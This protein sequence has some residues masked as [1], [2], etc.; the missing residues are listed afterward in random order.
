MKKF[1]EKWEMMWKEMQNAAI[2]QLR[3]PYPIIVAYKPM[4]K[5]MG[6]PQPLELPLKAKLY[7]H[8]L[9]IQD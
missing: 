1:R 9:I 6:K 7:I 8:L 3:P 4:F 2:R 5:V